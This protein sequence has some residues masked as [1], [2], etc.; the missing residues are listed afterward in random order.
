VHTLIRYGLIHSFLLIQFPVSAEDAE[1]TSAKRDYF[2]AVDGNKEALKSAVNA[3]A[4]LLAGRPADPVVAAYFGSTKLLES[5]STIAPWR[6]GKLAS[7]G[8][9]LLDRAVAQ[10]PENREVRF[11]RAASTYHL[12]VWFKRRQQ[13]EADFALLVKNIQIPAAGS[14]ES[15]LTAAS[16]Y[17]HG[18]FRKDASDIAGART[19]WE[20]AVRISPDSPA[21]RDAARRLNELRR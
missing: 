17:Y 5:A 1:M 18:S 9:T 14:F 20:E 12:P 7:E 19:A 10:A 11:L 3:F 6:K 16:F 2:A 4:L 21:G 13:S 15:R 8:L